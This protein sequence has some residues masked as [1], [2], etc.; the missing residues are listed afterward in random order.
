MDYIHPYPWFG[1]PLYNIAT[2]S[3]MVS[4]RLWLTSRVHWSNRGAM[5]CL[6]ATPKKYTSWIYDHLC[7]LFPS[8]GILNFGGLVGCICLT[9]PM[10][11]CYPWEPPFEGLSAPPLLLQSCRAMSD[12]RVDAP[13]GWVNLWGCTPLKFTKIDKGPG[14]KI[15]KLSTE[16]SIKKQTALFYLLGDSCAR[17]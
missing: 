2:A 13:C 12:G 17:D 4:Q 1:V 7:R 3:H 5:R 10:C 15:E 14:E 9:S 16:I 6:F 11:G 8:H